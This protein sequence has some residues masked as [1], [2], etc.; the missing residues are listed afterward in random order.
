MPYENLLSGLRTH[1]SGDLPGLVSSDSLSLSLIQCFTD[2]IGQTTDDVTLDRSQRNDRR[3]ARSASEGSDRLGER[4]GV[5][6]VTIVSQLSVVQVSLEDDQVRGG[7]FE[8]K[9]RRL[10]G[11]TP[12][13]ESGAPEGMALVLEFAL[14]LVLLPPSTH[15][16]QPVHLLLG[17]L[18]E[19]VSVDT[20]VQDPVPITLGDVGDEPRDL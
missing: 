3:G 17:G 7:E 18:R 19:E 1:L 5:R 10:S 8:E 4:S 15:G 14:L 6:Q 12:E 20:R 13:G 16:S 9:I 2:S 11:E